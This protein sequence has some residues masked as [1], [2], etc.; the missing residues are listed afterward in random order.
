[1]RDLTKRIVSGNVDVI[2]VAQQMLV[3]Q[4]WLHAGADVDFAVFARAGTDSLAGTKEE[5]DRLGQFYRSE[6]VEAARRLNDK[7]RGF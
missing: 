6:I 2:V 4:T 5:Q 7:Y 3:Y 1:M